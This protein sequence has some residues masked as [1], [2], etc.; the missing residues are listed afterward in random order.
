M[1][2]PYSN[3]YLDWNMPKHLA[4]FTFNSLKDGSI[5][6]IVSPVLISGQK[7]IKPFFNTIFRS[8]AYSPT[9]PMNTK[10]A[11][12]VGYD[13]SL[14][15]PP[16]PLGQGDH[17]AGTEEWSKVLP[18]LSSNKCS[19]GW[20]DM[21]QESDE[22]RRL[23]GDADERTRLLHHREGEADTELGSQAVIGETQFDN[24][25]PGWGRWKFGTKMEDA[26]VEFGV[27]EKWKN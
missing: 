9:F 10:L 27:G 20:F 3:H 19:V 26:I 13:L 8:I 23:A 11:S 4:N 21:K 5:Q 24:W 14:V 12:Y 15:Q 25:F 2:I 6:I 17:E 1:Q 7:S 22:S 18:L 16:L